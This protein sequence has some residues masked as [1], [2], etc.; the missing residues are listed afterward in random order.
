MLK[1]RFDHYRQIYD[2]SEGIKAR[3]TG[4]LLGTAIKRELNVERK[5]LPLPSL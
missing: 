2:N 4:I 5:L 1:R 3:T